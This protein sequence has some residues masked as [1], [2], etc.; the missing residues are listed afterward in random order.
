MLVEVLDPMNK[1]EREPRERF[2]DD[3]R[4]TL[5]ELGA[6][7]AFVP[8]RRVTSEWGMVD[9]LLFAYLV[10]PRNAEENDIDDLVTR[11]GYDT[12]KILARGYVNKPFDE[13][14]DPR[15]YVRVLARRRKLPCASSL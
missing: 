2:I 9:Q 11:I 4:E 1:G 7:E 14:R 5:R 13:C 8:R 3:V 12:T 15:Y 6:A 10:P